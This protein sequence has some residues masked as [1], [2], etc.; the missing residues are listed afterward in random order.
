M[1]IRHADTRAG[2]MFSSPAAMLAE[3]ATRG[4][5]V[6]NTPALPAPP[7]RQLRLLR[8]VSVHHAGAAS[9]Y[10]NRAD[11]PI[12]ALLTA[13][14]ASCS[15]QV[16]THQW[17]GYAATGQWVVSRLTVPARAM[18]STLL[19]DGRLLLMAGNGNDAVNF[20]AGT[21]TTKVWNPLTGAT[22]NIPTPADM[23]CSAHVVLSDGRVLIVGG[24]SAYPGVKGA[25]LFQGS[26]T[27]YVFS[28]RT[29]SFTR[30]NE[31]N[32]GHWYPTETK[33]GDGN[34]W[35]AG[36]LGQSPTP[37]RVTVSTDT[38]LFSMAQQRWLPQNAVTQ[39]GQYWGEYPAM[40]LMADGELFYTGTHTFGEQRVGTGASIYDIAAGTVGDVPGLPDPNLRDQSGSVLLPPAQNQTVMIASGGR[41]ETGAK[42]TNSVGIINLNAASPRYVRGPSV[43]G[44][45][46]IYQNLTT[47]FDRTVLASDGAST[48]RSLSKVPMPSAIYYPKTNRWRQIAAD[49]V[50]RNYHSGTEL[51][52]NGTVV[53]IGSNPSDG[54]L[55][56]HDVDLLPALPFP[57]H[58][59]HGQ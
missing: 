59:A 26:K 13:G 10:V 37:N 28:E 30:V 17:T 47:L 4:D 23:F 52:P 38:N 56:H 43:P 22:V 40:F 41:V 53:A 24:T 1:E 48:A 44:P 16:T 29:M 32:Q 58:Q 7:H 33:L 12:L 50:A 42:P 51:L 11:R 5:R 15:T 21:F 36:G 18:H 8:R 46:R 20:A 27:S 55:Q 19:P 39:T 35:M 49:P 34:V 31:T 45:G 14:A 3:G 2:Y 54:I 6:C 25:T 9:S 57:R